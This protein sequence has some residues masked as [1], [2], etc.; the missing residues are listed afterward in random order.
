MNI[1]VLLV[2]DEKDFADALA[3]F[4]K[5]RKMDVTVAYDG[6]AALQRIRQQE[7]DV[8]VLD[9]LMPGKNGIETSKEIRAL[10]PN[11]SIIILSGH[12]K[13]DTA[14]ESMKLDAFDYLIKPVAPEELYDKIL[15][16]YD[17][18]QLQANKPL[19]GQKPA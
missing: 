10:N 12:A 5:V 16:A 3:K 2:D 13:V 17:H 6:S 15:T 11:V 4:L 9:V 14:I 7:F 18:K 1:R 8:I 19:S